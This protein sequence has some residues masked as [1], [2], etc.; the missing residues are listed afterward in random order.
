M[1][2][3]FQARKLVRVID[4]KHGHTQPWVV[5]CEGRS[6]WKEFVVKVFTN[7]HLLD[8]PR[9]HGEFVGSW[10]CREFELLTPDV[11]WIEMDNSFLSSLPAA[12]DLKMDPTDDR[13]KFGSAVLPSFQHF[14][15]G[16]DDGYFRSLLPV[17]RLYAFDIFI[18]NGDRGSYKPNLLIS[19][20][21]AY[22]I[23]HEF[24]FEIE[25][26]TVEDIKNLILPGKFSFDHIARAVLAKAPTK[27]KSD[28]FADFK[29]YLKA[30]NLQDLRGVFNEVQN[31]GYDAK[32]ATIMEYFVFV[33]ANPSIFTNLLL[34]EIQ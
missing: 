25:E 33:K 14:S 13:P 4:A 9:V 3:T 30:L 29:E 22:L 26:T 31:K 6:G 10:L 24:A 21:S 2:E 11:A 20:S 12:L 27:T 28:F 16:L 17:D 1:F 34:R 18:R 8:R 7:D 23:D 5:L 15:P 19:Q 32:V